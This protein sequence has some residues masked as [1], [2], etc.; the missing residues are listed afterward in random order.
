[1]PPSP[2]A[3]SVSTATFLDILFIFI[4]Q[5]EKRIDRVADFVKKLGLIFYL[6]CY[7]RLKSE[8]MSFMKGDLLSK[9]RKLV[10]GFAK[11]E[12]VWLR[13]MEKA[14]PATFPHA[15]NK[16]RQITLPEDTYVNK[17]YQK[18]PDS[19]FE[20]PIKCRFVYRLVNELAKVSSFDPPAAREF[21]WR[22]LEL[23]EQ[24]VDEIDA[25]AVA[26]TE[27]RAERKARKQAYA[28]LK[29]ISKLQGKRLPPNPCPSAVKE[30][31]AE[32]RKLIKD[33]FFNPQS[34]KI[35]E[36]LKEERDAMLMDRR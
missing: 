16:L 33:R 35:V 15:Q 5:E 17:F 6:V 23:K 31:Q 9:T 20:D 22:V 10:K 26:D 27:Y 34:R 21:A 25:M 1:M 4:T 7:D 14:P 28:R 12:P 30:I 24:G 13:S 8:T 36:R 2:A 29:Q 18:H 3:I 32:E 19:K 11:T